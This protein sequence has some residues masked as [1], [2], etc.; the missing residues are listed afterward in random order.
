VIVGR[1]VWS[2]FAEELGI[3]SQPQVPLLTVVLCV[4]GAI[5]LANVIA[6]I[7][8]RAAARA[9]PAVVLRSE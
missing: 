6:I 7:P 8:A 4:L 5:L 9:A 1:W 3:L 2:F